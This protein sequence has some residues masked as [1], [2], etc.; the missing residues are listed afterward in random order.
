M[1]VFIRVVETNSFSSAA[2]ALLIDPT[3]VSRTIKALEIDLGVPLFIR[4]TRSITLTPEGSSFYRDCVKILQS[5]EKATHKFRADAL[6]PRGRLTVGMATGF[7]Q[8]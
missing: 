1:S 6:T 8:R 5:I 2:R 3:A 4:S 7:A